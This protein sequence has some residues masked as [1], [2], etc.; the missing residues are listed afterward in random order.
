MSVAAGGVRIRWDDLPDELRGWVAEVLGASVAVATSQ[1]GGFSPG[2]A[3]RVVAVNGRRAFVKAV[4]SSV[5]PHSPTLHRREIEVAAMLPAAAPAPRL[6]ASYDDGDWV[7]LVFDDVDGRHPATPWR[8]AE[9]EQVLHATRELADALTPS[10]APR[11][12]DA[13][14]SVAGGM[15]GW[16]DLRADPSAELQPWLRDHLDELCELEQTGADGLAGTTL[17]HCDLRADNVLL[18]EHSVRFVDWPW[19]ANGVAWVDTLFVLIDVAFH[20][21]HDHE[22]LLARYCPEADAAAVTGVLAGFAGFL[23]DHARR[24]AP[25]GLPTIRRFQADQARTTVDWL[26]K[27]MATGEF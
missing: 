1:P 12:R 27:R 26:R 16:R 23:V 20:G 2:S 9:L 15:H 5:N 17:L 10:P 13:R 6:L 19:A 11:L 4:A 24:P 25:P 14:E 8:A 18:T 21:G 22:A 3:D 7:A